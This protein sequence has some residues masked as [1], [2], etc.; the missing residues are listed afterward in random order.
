MTLNQI[1]ALHSPFLL[2]SFL[3]REEKRAGKKI[4]KVVVKSH[5]FLLD[6]KHVQIY[7]CTVTT[8]LTLKGKKYCRYR[9]TNILGQILSF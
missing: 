9:Q 1:F 8:N 5:A 2:P 3:K 6:Q 4:T 7:I